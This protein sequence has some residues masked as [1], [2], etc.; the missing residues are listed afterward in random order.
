MA[1][2]HS[3]LF[4]VK[5]HKEIIIVSKIMFMILLYFLMLFTTSLFIVHI[6]FFLITVM[7]ILP[8]AC[9]GLFSTVLKKFF[10]KV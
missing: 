1:A 3:N 7:V 9:T 5:L 10:I 4:R 8:D 2:S 6:S